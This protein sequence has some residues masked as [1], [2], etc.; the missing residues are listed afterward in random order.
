MTGAA[1]REAQLAAVGARDHRLAG[2]VVGVALQPDDEVDAL[3]RQRAGDDRRA[4]RV[5]LGLVQRVDHRPTLGGADGDLRPAH[6]RHALR[7]PPR[8]RALGAEHAQ[9]DE[10]VLE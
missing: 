6:P 2:G 4:H 1:G 3:D 10:L 9:L 7:R 8:R 5:A